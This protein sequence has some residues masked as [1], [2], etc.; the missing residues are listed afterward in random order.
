MIDQSY[1]RNPGLFFVFFLCFVFPGQAQS[2]TDWH[3]SYC[4]TLQGLRSKEAL[5]F[6]NSKHLK[7]KRQIILAIIDSGIDTT[8]VDLQAALW[9]NPKE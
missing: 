7:P 8:V 9:K 6:L 5:A 4:D 2:L 1:L 3:K